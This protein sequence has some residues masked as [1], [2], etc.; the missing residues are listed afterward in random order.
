MRVD[1]E[2]DDLRRFEAVV[3]DVVS[4]AGAIRNRNLEGPLENA[5]RLMKELNVEWGQLN[6]VGQALSD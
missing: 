4:F 6:I 3:G 2:V 1:V 5:K